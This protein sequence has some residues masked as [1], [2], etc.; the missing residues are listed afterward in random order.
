[1]IRVYLDTGPLG[2]AVHPRPVAGFP[3]WLALLS[4]NGA[5]VVIP[6]IADYEL[7]RE[8]LRLN[9]SQSID[10]LDRLVAVTEYVPIT[11]S[12]MLTAAGL[13]AQ[14]RQLGRST[15]DRHALDGDVILA[16]SALAGRSAERVVVATTNPGHIGRFVEAALWEDIS[17][18]R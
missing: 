3:E 9:R 5:T 12:I 15:A 8:L 10:R 18:L 13:W 11:T 1:M 14:V 7:R 17:P 4:D 6:E 16:A 2:F